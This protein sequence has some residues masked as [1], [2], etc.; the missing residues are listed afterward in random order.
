MHGTIE[1]S[2]ADGDTLTYR[3]VSGNSNAEAFGLGRAYRPVLSVADS[4][5]LDYETMTPAFSLLVSEY[6]MEP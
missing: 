1:A 2:D 4:A 3:I 6:Q 5:A